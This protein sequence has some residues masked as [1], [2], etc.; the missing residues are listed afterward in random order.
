MR[1]PPHARDVLDLV[2]TM[3]VGI[4]RDLQPVRLSEA[5][6]A[7]LPW[8]HFAEW[9][10]APPSHAR[11]VRDGRR[12]CHLCEAPYGTAC[13]PQCPHNYQMSCRDVTW[14][15]GFW[16]P[17]HMAR[18][19]AAAD[20]IGPWASA[21]Q[22]APAASEPPPPRAGQSAAVDP[23]PSTGTVAEP[24]GGPSAGPISE[25]DRLNA[26]LD[27]LE[28]RL[29]RAANE[30]RIACDAFEDVSDE[31]AAMGDAF[32]EDSGSDPGRESQS[33]SAAG[34]A[35]GSK[36]ESDSAAPSSGGLRSLLAAEDRGFPRAV[37]AGE[38]TAARSVAPAFVDRSRVPAVSGM[39]VFECVPSSDSDEDVATAEADI[40]KQLSEAR[41][42]KELRN[43]KQTGE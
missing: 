40:E 24:E 36:D 10:A 37:H 19:W 30:D 13:R 5:R 20:L 9:A 14:V 17:W 31:I 34:A 23:R 25:H 11:M 15:D 21:D 16:A 22:R 18:A 4:G 38:P 33:A 28:I 35:E 26:K 3:E 29:A 39:E 32:Y 27:A 6:V 7:M 42:A 41:E 43:D 8:G 12:L 1:L 2:E